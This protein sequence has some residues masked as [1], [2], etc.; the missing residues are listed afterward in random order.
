MPTAVK[1]QKSV[2][3]KL[4]QMAQDKSAEKEFEKK[5]KFLEDQPSLDF[6]GE[7]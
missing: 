4:A 3:S 1:K 7:Y 5:E 6:D 2:T